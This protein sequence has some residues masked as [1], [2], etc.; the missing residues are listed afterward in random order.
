MPR[1]CLAAV[2]A[3]VV[4]VPGLAEEAAWPFLIHALHQVKE[5]PLSPELL[6]LFF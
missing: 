3:G 1:R 5:I 2:G 4:S 6:K